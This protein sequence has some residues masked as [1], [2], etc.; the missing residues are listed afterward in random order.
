[1]ITLKGGAGTARIK[2]ASFATLITGM[3][4]TIT[5]ADDVTPGSSQLIATKLQPPQLRL[6]H[7]RRD[8]L[9]GILDTAPKSLIVASAPAGFGKTTALVDWLE[10]SNRPFAW[11]S[12]DRHDDDP[13]V[14]FTY[15]ASAL[16]PLAGAG[17]LSGLMANPSE[18]SL[19]PRIL[20][21]ALVEDLGGGPDGAVLVLEDFHLITNAT[22][23]TVI[24]DSIPHLAEN[25][26]LVI[27]T[28]SD[29]PLPLARL[30]AQGHM[31]D[32]R[33]SDLAFRDDESRLLL[34]QITGDRLPASAVEQLNKRVEGWAV[35]LQL[36]GLSLADRPDAGEFIESFSG[37]ERYVADY[38]VDE[39]LHRQ[40]DEVQTFLLETSVLDRLSAGLC[41]AVTGN[42]AAGEILEDLYRR[43]VFVTALDDSRQWFRYHNLFADL[44]RG[45]LEKAHPGG[46]AALLQKAAEWCESKKEIEDALRYAISSG[47]LRLAEQLW[48]TH[49]ELLLPQGQI[50]QLLTWLRLFP[51]QN[52]EANGEMLLG[53]AWASLFT[54]RSD[55]ALEDLELAGSLPP[56]SFRFDVLGQ[57]EIM[58]AMA[59]FNKGDPE[60]CIRFARRGLDLLPPGNR[61]LPSL[62]HLY[63]GRG[64]L[65]TGK[66][67]DALLD[68]TV[69]TDL[70]LDGGN[71]F[72][73]I[74]AFLALAAARIQSGDLNAGADQFRAALNLSDRAAFGGWDFPARGAA[75]IGL[76]VVAFE[77]YD[78]AAAVE[79][80]RRGLFDLKR[81]VYL[82]Y[83]VLGYRR[84]SEAESMQGNHAAA[85][86]ILEEASS[87]LSQF[88]SGGS[89]LARSLADCEVRNLLRSGDLDIARTR[90]S[91]IRPGQHQPA[92]LAHTEFD[93]LA[94]EIR[95]NLEQHGPE[96]VTDDLRH[97]RSL[98]GPNVGL[99][100]KALALEAAVL[101]SAD[102]RDGASAVLVEAF[103]KAHPGGWVRPF[104]DAGQSLA[105][106]YAEADIIDAAPELV[107]RVLEAI[108]RKATRS[109]VEQPL[110]DPLTPRELEVLDEIAAGRTNSEISDRLFISVGTAKRHAANIFL[111]LGAGHRTEAVAKARSLGMFD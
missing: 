20:T 69:A 16:R 15:L 32:L 42:P 27:G 105:D 34:D 95:L 60:A 111:K 84:W 8:R 23:Q 87:H 77:R 88:G 49:A 100:I 93:H 85:A 67:Q 71:Y 61:M 41:V 9:T 18:D 47:D 78:L 89:S 82:D 3:P 7:I 44:L 52:I 81:T 108:P 90:F 98:S 31:I 59:V 17:R 51:E 74:A 92:E 64:E 4:N 29:P 33:A 45:R 58:R 75:Q 86:E 101:M 1:M 80:F 39:V 22:I 43:N 37:D 103:E 65:A 21:S 5:S 107:R 26:T 79:S 106:L 99:D 104:V 53:R 66:I 11:Y 50:G 24:R 13:M 109:A 12:L 54:L 76:G 94:T 40:S 97:L 38:L 63:V 55:A 48:E 35:G 110:I 30:R 56:D 91:A 25:T 57:L 46:S 96:A 62:G 83:T 102:D 2:R 6:D 68:L 36:A 70:A 14:F 28:R 10:Q 72:A 73:G 19:Q